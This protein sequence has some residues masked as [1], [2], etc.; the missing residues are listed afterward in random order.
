ME[1]VER[2]KVVGGTVFRRGG[3]RDAF[4]ERLR[5]RGGQPRD[6]T[7]DDGRD[8]TQDGTPGSRAQALET[9]PHD[10][11]D[12]ADIHAAVERRG[13]RD[14][15]Q[16][17]HGGHD[18]TP[19]GA[20]APQHVGEYEREREDQRVDVAVGVG[21]DEGGRRA[22]VGENPRRRVPLGGRA[23]RELLDEVV[24]V[25]GSRHQVVH[26]RLEA[27]RRRRHGDKA[28]DGG[29]RQEAPHR[30]GNRAHTQ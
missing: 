27:Q 8:N 26:E 12:E 4:K 19:L 14:N 25:Q 30:A 6:H 29:R 13:C 2:L 1:L 3:G 15:R 18:E 7:H 20:L 16:R 21:I 17:A 11:D 28:T 23:L 22:R 5:G 9:H 10:D 24:G